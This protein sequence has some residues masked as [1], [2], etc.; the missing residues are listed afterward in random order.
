MIQT[1]NGSGDD[2]TV[3][4]EGATVSFGTQGLKRFDVFGGRRA[5]DS[6]AEERER[7]AIEKRDDNRDAARSDKMF[8]QSCDKTR[9]ATDLYFC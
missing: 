7:D 2:A 5:R 4:E 3:I 9:H 8:E 1:T 6:V